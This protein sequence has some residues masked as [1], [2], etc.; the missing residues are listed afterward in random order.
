MSS[1]ATRVEPIISLDTLTRMS[2][3]ALTE[4]YQN[5]SVPILTALS[6]EPHGRMLAMDAASSS[7]NRLVARIAAR[8]RFPWRGKAFSHRS[9]DLGDGIN[10]IRLGI[11]MKWYSFQTSIAPSVLDNEPCLY[12]NY[13]LD[14]N[15]WF[16]R[17]VRDEL[18]EV[19]P[20][21]YMGPA[22]L[23]LRTS[24]R[25]LLHFAV[26]LNTPST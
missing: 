10:R 5:A 17:R 15:P 13:D 7:T 11:D 21:L 25:R 1:A 23:R 19:S 9:A 2:P 22:L 6:G 24:H 18:R 3:P 12:L 20:G 16:I 4:L 8:T 14:E 26:D